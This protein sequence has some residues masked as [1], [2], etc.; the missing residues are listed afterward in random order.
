MRR[1][2]RRHAAQLGALLATY[3][4]V[5]AAM[6]AVAGS[7]WVVA[8]GPVLAVLA[9]RTSFLGHDVGHRQV[10]RG[11][12]RSRALGLLCG[13]LLSGLS[14]GWWVAKHNAH[15]AHPN[16]LE[17]DPDVRAGVLVW[18]DAQARG[19]TGAAAWWTRHQATMFVPLLL[20]EALNLHVSS[21]R[22]VAT[23]GLRWRAAEA[24]TLLSHLAAYVVLVAL[25]TAGPWQ[26]LAL[27]A[28][29][30]GLQGLNLGCAFAPNH[31]GMPVLD[32][33]TARDPLLRQVLTSRNVRGGR[34]LDAAF[35]GL[36][37]QIEH[38]LFPS[39]PRANLRRARPVV[40]AYCLD[41][42]VPYAETTLAASYA[43]SL[44]H[45]RS[46]GTGSR[47]G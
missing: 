15:H 7:W 32:A 47:A 13:N 46:V 17:T 16:D 2:P 34:V 36:N 31:K 6:L 18:D 26:A 25:T 37:M 1:R 19:R 35:G 8:A 22:A 40:R 45:L 3:V 39:M 14:Y 33:E 5:V 10:V 30:K 4:V 44:R 41:R 23:P 29:H 27:V 11:A 42:G 24:L 20:L 21:L 38:H 43:L 28:A 9:V 12:G